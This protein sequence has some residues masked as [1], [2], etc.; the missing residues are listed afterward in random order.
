MAD[1]RR[2]FFRTL[3][4]FFTDRDRLEPAVISVLAGAFS[5][6]AG[7]LLIAVASKN[8]GESIWNFLV[9]PV[10]RTY[11]LYYVMVMM[12]PITFAGLALC[13][14]YQA[15]Y[16]TL[17]IDSTFYMGAVTAAAVGILWPLPPGLHPVVAMVVSGTVGGLIGMIPAVL[18]LKWRANE[19]VSSIMLNYVFYFLGSC[20]II[21]FLR[22][23]NQTILASLP[24]LES[25][26]LAKLIPNT[27]LHAGFLIAAALV[28]AVAVYLYRTKW[29][30]QIRMVGANPRFAAY[31]GFSVAGVV[32]GAHF[33]SG[34]IGGVG[35]AVEMSGMYKA[36]IWQ[37]DPSYAWDGVIVAM[38]ARRNPKFVP[39]SALFLAYIR[40]GADFMSRRG[41]VAFEFITLVQGMIIL[42]LASDTI[43]NYFRTKRAQAQALRQEKA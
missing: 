16:L 26:H 40:V 30:Y 22:D 8:P 4:M 6:L 39:V 34:F 33:V 7:V 32:L 43:V 23:R 20:V 13:I 9:G 25:F 14:V 42:I 5:L 38:L 29:G 41:D 19:L 11:N 10:L 21:Y 1:H 17:I 18:K 24:F 31:T 12:V 2:G 37:M 15:R 28:V 35:G 3:G 36:F 27:Q